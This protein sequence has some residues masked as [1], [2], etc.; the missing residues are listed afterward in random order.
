MNNRQIVAS[1]NQIANEL[2]SNGLYQE[3]NVVT[4]VMVKISQY[5]NLTPGSAAGRA[6]GLNNPD[7]R[8]IQYP[9]SPDYKPNPNL[10]DP[11]NIQ[12]PGSPDYRPY[13][14]TGTEPMP[15]FD[16]VPDSPM[17]DVPDSPS[18]STTP[19]KPPMS[20]KPSKPSSKPGMPSKPG[21]SKPSEPKSADG[22]DRWVNKAENIY[23]AW[24]SK[25]G[26]PNSSAFGLVKD[27][28][29]YM[30]KVKSNLPTTLHGS[31]D[32]KIKRVQEM[33]Q[34]IF[35]GLYNPV[36]APV[37]LPYGVVGGYPKKGVNPFT[38]GPKMTEK[39]LNYQARQEG[40]SY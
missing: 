34:N 13:K 28:V 2:D 36:L 19:T 20:N 18:K 14:P 17:D 39:Q 11:R 12:Y 16:L 9:G 4:N 23:N 35:D 30:K 1:L 26:D 27:I 5:T 21:S 15:P 40:K 29:D 25:G 3:A 38:T 10:R 33:L 22:L 7:R 6:V 8:N 37:T 24:G 31:A 32:T